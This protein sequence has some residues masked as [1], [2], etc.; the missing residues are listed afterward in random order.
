M[1]L[2]KLLADTQ[3]GLEE[4]KQLDLPVISQTKDWQS[5]YRV[6]MQLGRKLP[7][8]PEKMKQA[9]LLVKGCE[10]RAW[11][12]HY[13]DKA[14]NKHFFVLDSEA[15]IV[16]GLMAIMLCLVN[17]MSTAELTNF[18]LSHQFEQLNLKPYLSQSRGNGLTA[19]IN[20]IKSCVK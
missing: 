14:N 11:L 10:S 3:A 5:R 16:K 15:R 13:H 18:D 7:A 20:H 6:L 9:D 12:L 4:I 2:E 19:M 1:K 17:G 8:L